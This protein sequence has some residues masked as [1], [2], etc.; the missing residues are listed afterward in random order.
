MENILVNSLLRGIP[1]IFH[2][3]L[4]MRGYIFWIMTF[5]S[6]LIVKDSEYNRRVEDAS[7]YNILNISSPLILFEFGTYNAYG[8]VGMIRWVS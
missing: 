7:V 4:K 2:K 5:N 8:P 6:V 3:N 1:G